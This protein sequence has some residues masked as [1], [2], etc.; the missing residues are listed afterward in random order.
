[1]KK[2]ND[3]KIISAADLK[4][5][6]QR[7]LWG[8]IPEGLRA[9]S[10]EAENSVIKWRCI[11]GSSQYKEQNWELLSVAAA[12]VVADFTACSNIEEEYLVVSPPLKMNHLEH[13]LFLRHEPGK[14]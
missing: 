14:F 9:V 7:A 8:N 1:M 3:E 10:I 11:F 4:I 5:S 2:T 13:L 6:G 12:E